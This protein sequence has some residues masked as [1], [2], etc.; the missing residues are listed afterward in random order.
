MKEE[1]VNDSEIQIIR[2]GKSHGEVLLSLIDALADYERL[3]NP[4]SA[5][6]ERLLQDAFGEHSRIEVFLAEAGGST[7]GYAIVFETYSS[8]LALPTLYLEDLFVLSEYRGREVGYHLFT[9]CVQEALARGCGRMEWA[10]LDWNRLAIDFYERL[11][12]RP[13][14]EWLPYRLS[15]VEMEEIVR[16]D[17]KGR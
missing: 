9:H 8:F 4:D 15:K 13:L 6:R 3:P 16:T 5:A 14:K 10:V 12:A 7:A 17:S 2:A 11:G 1:C